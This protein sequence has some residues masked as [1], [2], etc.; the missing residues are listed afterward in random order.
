MDV[1]K[2]AVIVDLIHLP[3]DDRTL[4]VIRENREL[5]LMT[6]GDLM[7]GVAWEED[8]DIADAELLEAA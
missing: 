3:S 7:V 4:N 1:N 2:G 8:Q 5:E 6:M